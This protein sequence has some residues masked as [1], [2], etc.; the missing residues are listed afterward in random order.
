MKE[1]KELTE[2]LQLVTLLS[3]LYVLTLII[4]T[5]IKIYTYLIALM[6]I[7]YFWLLCFVFYKLNDVPHRNCGETFRGNYKSS[8]ISGLD[9]ITIE[10]LF[11]FHVE[12]FVF[13]VIG[14]TRVIQFLAL[15]FSLKYIINIFLCHYKVSIHDFEGPIMFHHLGA[16]QLV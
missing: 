1:K 16:P 15:Q 2:H 7:T 10:L 8:I 12:V 13:N 3:L 11:I 6:F 14:I 9:I 5:I 4:L